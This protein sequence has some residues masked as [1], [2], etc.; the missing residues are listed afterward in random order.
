MRVEDFS[1]MRMFMGM[2]HKTMG[3]VRPIAS[4]LLPLLLGNLVLPVLVFCTPST[5]LGDASPGGGIANGMTFSRDGNTLTVRVPNLPYDAP[6]HVM[7][8]YNGASTEVVGLVAPTGGVFTADI[9]S[10]NLPA[11]ASYTVELRAKYS[12]LDYLGANGTQYIAPFGI[13]YSTTQKT[14]VSMRAQYTATRNDKSSTA[15]GF[16][17]AGW[18]WFGLATNGR[19][20]YYVGTG[21]VTASPDAIDNVLDTS[22]EFDGSQNRQVVQVG[23]VTANSSATP[24]PNPSN[25]GLTIF[26]TDN[27]GNFQSSMNLYWF[28]V[29]Q[30]GRTVADLIPVSDNG[31]GKLLDLVTG[32]LLANAG[33]GSF[34]LGPEQVAAGTLLDSGSVIGGLPPGYT[35]LQ[36]IDS[37]TT[38]SASLL[39]DDFQLDY[40]NCIE[41]K[42]RFG[43]TGQNH[44]VF[45]Q[46]EKEAKETYT[47]FA[48][49]TGKWRYDYGKG[50]EES[51]TWTNGS[52]YAIVTT[53]NK[54]KIN[55]AT[56][57]AGKGSPGAGTTWNH[58]LFL[59]GSNSTSGTT[60]YAANPDINFARMRMYCFKV[61]EG[62]I[63]T[64]LRLDLVPVRRDSDSLVGML[65]RVSGRF[66]APYKKGASHTDAEKFTAGELPTMYLIGSDPG[67]SSS[68]SF[69][70]SAV[71]TAYGWNSNKNA[72]TAVA[73][74]V[75]PETSYVV[76]AGKQLRTPADNNQITFKGARLT[77][78]GNGSAFGE[79]MLKCANDGA[80][81]VTVNRLV[82]KGGKISHSTNNSTFTLE[83]GLEFLGATDET[84]SQIGLD[85]TAGS[86]VTRTLVIN[87]LMTGSG[88]VRIT[89]SGTSSNEKE[90]A[91]TI[92]N[93]GGFTG[94]IAGPKDWSSAYAKNLTLNLTGPFGGELGYMDTAPNKTVA[95]NVNHDA[96][97]PAKGLRMTK[98]AV[99]TAQSGKL[100]FTATAKAASRNLVTF[101]ADA[102]VTAAA[103]DGKI[104]FN[105]EAIPAAKLSVTTNGDG[106]KTLVS[107]FGVSQWFRL[108]IMKKLNTSDNMFQLAEFGLYS[109]DDARQ[110]L[111]SNGSFTRNTTSAQSLQPGQYYFGGSDYVDKGESVD[112]L[113][114][115]KCENGNHTKLLVL[116][117]QDLGNADRSKREPLYQK[118]TMRLP[119]GA[120]KVV[121]YNLCSANDTKSSSSRTPTAWKVESSADGVNW[122]LRD[123]QEEGS[124]KYTSENFTWYNNG[125]TGGQPSSFYALSATPLVELA[126]ATVEYSP[127]GAICDG[128]THRPAVTVKVGGVTVPAG[129]YTVS[130]SPNDT[131]AEV[132]TYVPTITGN[133]EGGGVGTVAAPGS[134]VIEA[135]PITYEFFDYVK[136]TGWVKDTGGTAKN[137]S[138]V[139]LDFKLDSRHSVAASF[140]IQDLSASWGCIWCARGTDN[141]NSMTLFCNKE[142]K[143]RYDFATELSK[144]DAYANETVFACKRYDVEAKGSKLTVNGGAAL[145]FI[146][147]AKGKEPLAGETGG[148]VRLFATC[149][150]TP[151]H[152]ANLRLCSFEVR[153]ELGKTIHCLRPAR[154]NLANKLTD[155]LYDTVTERFYASANGNALVCGNDEYTELEYVKSTR[156]QRLL[157]D[158]R[159][160]P[161]TWMEIDLQF[162]GDFL[163]GGGIVAG[164]TSTFFTAP[165]GE[166]SASYS[167]NFGGT[168]GQSREVFFWLHQTNQGPTY[169][170]TFA[171]TTVKTR[172]T[173]TI[174]NGEA[175]CKVTW[176]DEEYSGSPKKTTTS[177]QP[178]SLFGGQ[179]ANFAAYNMLVYEWKVYESDDGTKGGPGEE[180]VHDFVPMKNQDGWVGLYDRVEGRFHVSGSDTHLEAGRTIENNNYYLAVDDT[181]ASG[182]SHTTSFDAD[183]GHWSDDET[184]ASGISHRPSR[185]NKYHVRAGRVLNTAN[186]GADETFAGSSLT[187]AGVLNIGNDAAT[188]GLECAKHVTI[189]SLVADGGTIRLMGNGVPATYR[190]SGAVTLADEK[191]LSVNMAGA[192]A[193]AMLSA[194]PRLTAAVPSASPRLTAA[195]G[196][197]LGL[198][199][200]A[201][202]SG[203]GE[204]KVSIPAA[205]S[206]GEAYKLTLAGNMSRFTGTVTFDEACLAASRNFAFGL[207]SKKFG[208][209]IA[210]LPGGTESVVA[211]YAALDKS[212]GFDYGSTAVPEGLKNLTLYGLTAIELA[213]DRL[214]LISFPAGAAPDADEFTVTLMRTKDDENPVV[215]K[216]RAGAAEYGLE[217]VEIGGRP[218]L[219]NRSARYVPTL[220]GEVAIADWTEGNAPSAA[221]GVS[222]S[223]PEIGAE[224]EIKVEYRYY[225]GVHCD[226]KFAF[227]PS[228]DTPVG[229][230]YVRPEVD[231]GPMW[232]ATNGEPRVFHVLENPSLRKL[233]SGYTG[234]EF[235]SSYQ[236]WQGESNVNSPCIALQN[237]DGHVSAR[238]SDWVTTTVMFF[239]AMEWAEVMCQADGVYPNQNRYEF[240]AKMG[241]ADL[242]YGNLAYNV[243][244]GVPVSS[245]EKTELSTQFEGANAWLVENATNLGIRLPAV[246]SIAEVPTMLFGRLY[247]DTRILQ[248]DF[249]DVHYLSRMR[250]YGFRVYDKGGALIH[251][252]KPCCRD[253]DGVAGL[254]DVADGTAGNHFYSSVDEEHA[255]TA[256]DP[257]PAVSVNVDADYNDSH[258]ACVVRVT[259][260][261]ESLGAKN[262]TSASM[263]LLYGTDGRL[264]HRRRMAADVVNGESAVW[265]LEDMLLQSQLHLGVEL[266]NDVGQV[267]TNVLGCMMLP[268]VSEDSAHP[269]EY[270]GQSREFGQTDGIG[271]LTWTDADRAYFDG[272]ALVLIYTNINKSGTFT[273]PSEGID[274]LVQLLAV[275]GGG[276][277]GQGAIADAPVAK[278]AVGGGAG[279]GGMLLT[280]SEMLEAGQYRVCVGCGRA[281]GGEGNKGKGSSIE[282]PNEF[283]F[284]AEG[285]CCGGDVQSA[286][287]PFWDSRYTGG[288]T[289]AYTLGYTNPQWLGRVSPRIPLEY[290]ITEIELCIPPGQGHVGAYIGGYRSNYFGG[291]PDWPLLSGYIT[292]SAGGGGAGSRGGIVDVN[293]SMDAAKTILYAE[294]GIGRSSD[295]TG[296]LIVYAGGGAGGRSNLLG[297]DTVAGVSGGGGG[298]G[299]TA[300]G[301][302]AEQGVDGKG[303]GGAGCSAW[304]DGSGNVTL[305]S[306]SRHGAR[307]G[308]G[309][310]VVRF[311]RINSYNLNFDANCDDPVSMPG[312]MPAYYKDELPGSVGVAKRADDEYEFLGWFDEREGGKQYYDASGT[313]VDG[314]L[315][316]PADMTLY[317]HWKLAKVKVVLH[318]NG[319]RPGTVGSVK[320]KYGEP[321]PAL[322]E[323]GWAPTHDK[324]TFCGYTN[325]AG[326]LYYYSDGTGARNS[327]LNED[328]TLYA[329]WMDFSGYTLI[330]YIATTNCQYLSTGVTPHDAHIGYTLD[331]WNLCYTMPVPE[332]PKD[333]QN[334]AIAFG[335][336][337]WNGGNWNGVYVGNWNDGKY[338]GQI[339]HCHAP[340]DQRDFDP[341][342]SNAF[343]MRMTMK[344]SGR[345]VEGGNAF[346]DYTLE[347]ISNDGAVTSLVQTAEHKMWWEGNDPYTPDI[348]NYFEGPIYVGAVDFGSWISWKTNNRAPTPEDM[349]YGG[350]AGNY[351]MF[352]RVTIYDGDEIIYDAI[353]AIEKSTG[354]VGLLRV[355]GTQGNVFAYSETVGKE[356]G[357]EFV[358]PRIHIDSWIEAQ[359]YDAYGA[360]GTP[361]TIDTD[362]LWQRVRDFP[363]GD[364]DGRMDGDPLAGEGGLNDAGVH[365]EY[366]RPVA[367]GETPVWTKEPPTFSELGEHQV[368][369][370]INSNITFPYPLDEAY[371]L[372]K[373]KGV[374]K[375]TV[376]P[377]GSGLYTITGIYPGESKVTTRSYPWVPNRHWMTNVYDRVIREW[378]NGSEDNRLT[379]TIWGLPNGDGTRQQLSIEYTDMLTKSMATGYGNIQ[380]L[381]DREEPDC[382]ALAYTRIVFD[383]CHVKEDMT[384][385]SN[386]QDGARRRYLVMPPCQAGIGFVFRHCQLEALTW[387]MGNGEYAWDLE[388]SSS[389][390]DVYGM[391]LGPYVGDVIWTNNLHTAKNVSTFD[392]DATANGSTVNSYG[393]PN[394]YVFKDNRFVR[395]SPG[396]YLSEPNWISK[397]EFG[398]LREEGLDGQLFVDACELGGDEKICDIP[399]ENV[400][401]GSL[402]PYPGYRAYRVHPVVVKFVRAESEAETTPEKTTTL[403]SVCGKAALWTGAVWNYQEPDGV[404]P[405]TGGP[406]LAWKTKEGRLYDP[407]EPFGKDDVTYYLKNAAIDVKLD[408]NGGLPDE[409][410]TVP[411][412]VYPGMPMPELTGTGWVRTKE[413][414]LCDGYTNTAG[415][416]YYYGDGRSARICD[417]KEDTTLYANWV[418]TNRYVQ[419]N[420][421]ATTNCQFLDTGVTPRNAHFGFRLDYMNRCF[422]GYEETARSGVANHTFI[423]GTEGDGSYG[424]TLGNWCDQY[425]SNGVIKTSSG[426]QSF[427]HTNSGVHRGNND[428]DP[429]LKRDVRQVITMLDNPGHPSST[430]EE[431]YST[432]TVCEPNASGKMVPVGEPQD[433]SLW[434]DGSKD[435]YEYDARESQVGSI[436]I[437]ALN[438]VVFGRWRWDEGHYMMYYRVTFY[439]GNE[440]IYDAIPVQEKDPPYHIGLLRVGGTEGRVFAYSQTIQEEFSK[441][442]AEFV[443]PRIHIDKW[444]EQKTYDVTGSSG[445]PTTIDTNKLW[446]QV[447]DFPEGDWDGKVYGDPLAGEGGLTNKNVRIEYAL[448][449]AKDVEPV[450]SE[451]APTFTTI[452]VHPVWFRI[453]SDVS[454]PYPE[455]TLLSR[456]GVKGV[457]TVTLVRDKPTGHYTIE[458][459]LPNDWKAGR[460]NV[461]TLEYPWYTDE[462]WMTNVYDN[463][464]GTGERQ[465]D[466]ASCGGPENPLTVTIFPE[467]D[468]PNGD[469]LLP[470]TEADTLTT[471]KGVAANYLFNHNLY[472]NMTYVNVVFQNAKSYLTDLSDKRS[473]FAWC[474]ASSSGQKGLGIT[475]DGG[476][477]CNAVQGQEV[478]YY[479]FDIVCRNAE[480]AAPAGFQYN[481]GL[482]N[483]DAAITN[484]YF[485]VPARSHFQFCCA[486]ENH[487]WSIEGSM[488]DSRGGEAELIFKD[489]VYSAISPGLEILGANRPTTFS[490]AN[491]T[492]ERKGPSGVERIPFG[493]DVLQTEAK[494]YVLE[495]V[496]SFVRGTSAA[497]MYK[498]DIYDKVS[499]HAYEV[500]FHYCAV[501]EPETTV[502]T[503]YTLYN[504]RPAE[505]GLWTVKTNVYNTSIVHDA[506]D[507]GKGMSWRKISNVPFSKNAQV[508]EDVDY[509]LA[510]GDAR[511]PVPRPT[512]K[513]LTYTGYEQTGVDYPDE[514]AKGLYEI[515]GDVRKTHH[516]DDDY[517]AT[518]T[519]KDPEH[520]RWEGDDDAPVTIEIPWNI[521]KA[522]L[523]VTPVPSTP[524]V[525]Y[526]EPYPTCE[527]V[528]DE[529]KGEDTAD[530]AEKFVPPSVRPADGYEPGKP[531]G[532]YRLE[533]YGGSAQDYVFECGQCEFEVVRRELTVTS[534][535]EPAAVI[536]GDPVPRYGV[537]YAGF[538]AGEDESVLGFTPEVA[539]AYKPTSNTGTYPVRFVGEKPAVDGNYEIVYVQGNLTVNRREY[540]GD[541][542]IEIGVGGEISTRPA[543][544]GFVEVVHLF[545]NVA[546]NVEFI[547]PRPRDGMEATKVRYLVI[548]GG[549]AGGSAAGYEGEGGLGGGGGGA[550]RLIGGTDEDC[551]NL[552]DK[553]HTEVQVSVGRG[554]NAGNVAAG[555]RRGADSSL[556]VKN[557]INL[558]AK[559]GGA[560]GWYGK[561]GEDLAGGSGGG[562]AANG[563]TGGAAVGVDDPRTSDKPGIGHAGGDGGATAAGAGG[564]AGGAGA[565]GG[566]GVVSDIDFNAPDRE[567]ARGGGVGGAAAVGGAA[568]GHGGAGGKAGA[569]EGLG[570]D[571]GTGAVILRYLLKVR[572]VSLK[573]KLD[574]KTIE[575]G[576]TNGYPVVHDMLMGALATEDYKLEGF[577]YYGNDQAVDNENADA[578]WRW[579]EGVNCPETNRWK[580]V[581]DYQAIFALADPHGTCWEGG[582]T[583]PT[584]A[585]VLRIV[586]ATNWWSKLPA[587]AISNV[588][589]EWEHVVQPEQ[590]WLRDAPLKFFNGKPRICPTMTNGGLRVEG[591]YCKDGEPVRLETEEYLRTPNRNCH[592]TFAVD[593]TWNYYGLTTQYIVHVWFGPPVAPPDRT[594]EYANTNYWF[595]V[596]NR[597]YD[598]VVY[599]DGQ[600]WTTAGVYRVEITLL[601]EGE[602][603]DWTE[604]TRMCLF[605]VRKATNWWSKVP[606]LKPR[607]WREGT[608]EEDD[609]AI[610][611][612]EARPSPISGGWSHGDLTPNVGVEFYRLGDEPKCSLSAS[613]LA[614][615]P[616]GWYDVT[617]TVGETPNYYGLTN[618]FAI[619][620]TN[621]VSWPKR[622]NKWHYEEKVVERSE[623]ASEE[624]GAYESYWL[625]STRAVE[626]GF[627]NPPN[628]TFVDDNSRTVTLTTTNEANNLSIEY[629]DPVKRPYGTWPWENALGA[630]AWI[631]R[632]ADG[633]VPTTADELKIGNL[634]KTCL[635]QRLAVA[636]VDSLAAFTRPEGAATTT[637]LT[638]RVPGT[639]HGRAINEDGENFVLVLGTGVDVSGEATNAPAEYVSEMYPYNNWYVRTVAV[640]PSALRAQIEID[641]QL[642][643]DGGTAVVA[644]GKDETNRTVTVRAADPGR[645]AAKFGWTQAEGQ[646]LEDDELAAPESSQSAW[647]LAMPDGTNRWTEITLD[648]SNGKPQ[649][650]GLLADSATVKVLLKKE[651][652]GEE[653]Q[654]PEPIPVPVSDDP[655]EMA[656]PAGRG[657]NRLIQ[658]GETVRYTVYFE[659]KPEAEADA[660]SVHIVNAL[661][662][663]LDWGTF[664]AEE[665]GFGQ[666]GYDRGLRGH[667]VGTS[668]VAVK[669]TNYSVRTTLAFDPATGVADWL[670]RIVMPPPAGDADG[671]PQNEHLQTGF[672]PPNDEN[673][674]GEG[675]VTYSV[676]VREDAPRGVVITNTA[677]IRFDL[678][679]PIETDPAWWNTVDGKVKLLSDVLTEKTLD[680]VRTRL[681]AAIEANPDLQE[682]RVS[683][684]AS[685]VALTA[686]LGI[687]P[688]LLRD[689]VSARAVY[690]EPKV[691]IVGFDAAAGMIRVRIDPGDGNTI[692][693]LPNAGALRVVGAGALDEGMEFM[694]YTTV[695]GSEDYVSKGEITLG[696]WMRG[697]KFFK[698][699]VAS[700]SK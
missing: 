273:V 480:L 407:A 220:T 300:V 631:C 620:V 86:D 494:V 562:A 54:A 616:Q 408:P 461:T 328:T 310:V 233:P 94:T 518:A 119:D 429:L 565:A 505:D 681:A 672:L 320:A 549:G 3:F 66:Y 112:N 627:V 492:Y 535:A 606:G 307:G 446:R 191:R 37:S 519:L 351:M 194:S 642:Y 353:P 471:A 168:S 445:W 228:K 352:Y 615:L 239:G 647:T 295:I 142:K 390:I 279:A 435:P 546:Q 55:A 18:C 306:A 30:G 126:A 614:S 169:N 613:E 178:L 120:A 578:G 139:D 696:V 14:K 22:V 272:S 426:Q 158:Y 340:Y 622:K 430:A 580:T 252:L 65:D 29:E 24:K 184:A 257:C 373:G 187:L 267:V 386:Q 227:T 31:T 292:V 676:R 108:T 204:L 111:N 547:P 687:S 330:A 697:R 659:N 186:S 140:E 163:Y 479:N 100:A 491:V 563:G 653:P 688:L 13:T 293:D 581:G 361:T 692:T 244:D 190:L 314:E 116:S 596:T 154:R 399:C 432:Y 341:M 299:S 501:S 590:G 404:A 147:N 73:H 132:G 355:G 559:G 522:Q 395:V 256:G 552:P 67:A 121:K 348:H 509:Y 188:A 366:A 146:D 632:K 213:T 212:R 79:L 403:Y 82:C 498:N 285:G 359:D 402:G 497:P 394:G 238:A 309:I 504:Y 387:C 59:F 125:G 527:L 364:W 700:P 481:F 573:L 63:T 475:Y 442:G 521:K 343:R 512:A 275:G 302:Y 176:G 93:A 412:P 261:V 181:W 322:T 354:H 99:P 50:G 335:S 510:A 346:A 382:A 667:S 332:V 101:P 424:V 699:E 655:N 276:T 636:P 617:F 195:G 64:P 318:P 417:L 282:G 376:L 117:V 58:K 516:A 325:T 230:Y 280:E 281:P 574:A 148:N 150:N 207:E 633:T 304:Y 589:Q 530:T 500:R 115:G 628:V 311:M 224:V 401:E 626:Y 182:A 104:K 686:D 209:Q 98:A 465:W 513:D 593:D 451:V 418:D 384:P 579:W 414:C 537:D 495:N 74:T 598:S 166:N 141:K 440:I 136:T 301:C 242:Q 553:N 624:E 27:P 496:T 528:Y 365:I 143:W 476:V 643:D 413:G 110:N 215:L 189:G 682:I 297:D 454:F 671:W 398:N 149:G 477:V 234:V 668:E 391:G 648:V 599:C 695:C 243:H 6:G 484:C 122:V 372:T 72:T 264:S 129:A 634:L 270:K 406:E 268:S 374:A 456:A 277:G 592:V 544:E 263:F 131:F 36:Y 640:K 474:S 33:S 360:E 609:F 576:N 595:D 172:N 347:K 179:T 290:W 649:G 198:V 389:T 26:A 661:S 333:F 443:A 651:D 316:E 89:G 223:V 157:T 377:A 524:T 523:K 128:E 473:C 38:G 97:D 286:W 572:Q 237:G 156:R 499:V 174:C 57:L 469:G 135:A 525:G 288:S 197:G 21:P 329:K 75:G 664:A 472:Y 326:V 434:F 468:G 331:F 199:V 629:D 646:K 621:G 48:I 2:S 177:A 200:D 218:T 303:G 619:C 487:D 283:V 604:R 232:V 388:I 529:F 588:W 80:K 45:C 368:W 271:G 255:V 558:V 532:T 575:Y 296:E 550:G 534:Y 210:A 571:G 202:F 439:D 358:A 502:V 489:N 175:N 162:D 421:I 441:P 566:A 170:K 428:F 49:S 597:L 339:H 482:W 455:T 362:K 16:S 236:N 610:D 551:F 109:A 114:D 679:E 214:P 583:A 470:I 249:S 375:V 167:A 689:G 315:K 10:L 62:D 47:L 260:T 34:I 400:H 370:R 137:G 265:V 585:T 289:G 357:A 420:Y 81:T 680:K 247:Y 422:I 431:R 587:V 105:G 308:N 371:H 415:V 226:P 538:A 433:H 145:D 506:P 28:R 71:G 1:S 618:H 336:T 245:G 669:G 438:H 557:V 40:A 259:A 600:D 123:C 673:H 95:I 602:W 206:A 127:A 569:A 603:T 467:G 160:N 638:L 102:T 216:A 83:G 425:V 165:G 694:S 514:E 76:P 449:V 554:G 192:G 567:Y 677:S 650:E 427:F 568:F 517:V 674:C 601:E 205:A 77:L 657:E 397:T 35:E 486:P 459:I 539:C 337:H 23:S 334:N 43:K 540:M 321:M 666:F 171:E 488:Q 452:G 39:L 511:T 345:P 463:V 269:M 423:F 88:L 240:F 106:T 151:G 185:G 344:D 691:T 378:H 7:L 235:I 161:K 350:K 68:S 450:W 520:Y 419:I 222:A 298:A 9:S 312:S 605:T 369:F 623:V 577:R 570:A 483:G 84:A 349:G 134:F 258:D 383:N 515:A 201:S 503:N 208:G 591:Y 531:I 144:S 448:P 173:L 19:N 130:W 251:D 248:Y 107:D 60:P 133:K 560:G 32:R 490:Y 15:W 294:P 217:V 287:W 584:N 507:P 338:H 380:Y 5:A 52:D 70:S 457:A 607:I 118:I 658:P 317:A 625:N 683:G 152:Y 11:N 670:M 526:G 675:F 545:T 51:S 113:F 25:A 564:G 437:G 96:L 464:L 211:N 246:E 684:D 87:S 203:G 396:K 254:Y 611:C 159:P 586:K 342:M 663:Y 324:Y 665:T 42:V 543:G 612:G 17:S 266:A 305:S 278:G 69:V 652:P 462:H 250:L 367:S 533:A 405:D 594:W 219:V 639:F 693:A 12:T 582:S 548:G 630:G 410:Y 444:I 409:I 356:G 685:Y 41:T 323:P 56:E 644:F 46:R 447:C 416:L 654:R 180:L 124:S 637:T 284:Y 379:V 555:G 85:G 91:V 196:E 453:T 458:G 436:L 466:N 363:E 155:G 92:A 411:D 541:Y 635:F 193:V 313:H 542:A 8:A 90:H 690:A 460:R 164:Q 608:L 392:F 53:P 262:A 385:G 656:G 327:D 44:A 485:R 153:D 662:E 698:V 138:Y 678:N 241:R 225:R 274:P 660:Q 641:G 536:V 20:Y 78:E 478:S 493:V 253:S 221:S 645:A 103:F 183:S 229:T 291:G 231:A 381:Y 508:T 319:G 561:T 556:R 61:H 393:E 4:R